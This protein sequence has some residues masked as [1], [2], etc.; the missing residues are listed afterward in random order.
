MKFLEKLKPQKKFDDYN[1][2]VYREQFE[3]SL[4]AEIGHLHRKEFKED[5]KFELVAVTRN[6]RGLPDWYGQQIQM[7][8]CE[9][10]LR[11]GIESAM[12]DYGK[13]G[14]YNT[15]DPEYGDIKKH[16]ILPYLQLELVILDHAK[17]EVVV[18]LRTEKESNLS[19]HGIVISRKKGKWRFDE[20]Y[21]SDY[22][23]QFE[24]AK[25]KDSFLRQQIAEAEAY[26]KECEAC[27][28]KGG[29]E[30]AE[31]PVIEAARRMAK[32]QIEVLR[33]QLS[34]KVPR[35]SRV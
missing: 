26:L 10:K 25:S 20:G 4:L 7:L 12:A 34:R 19:E 3:G 15:E 5:E 2:A 1:V 11:D 35:K 16:G 13:R 21:L 6:H 32:E 30:L 9:G 31:S 24:D 17:Q 8:L 33:S 29:K 22:L 23:S 14:G 27:W 28:K 18:V